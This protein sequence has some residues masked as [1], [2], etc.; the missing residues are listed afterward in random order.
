MIDGALRAAVRQQAGDRCEFCGMLQKHTAFAR[1]HIEHVIPRQHAGSDDPAN[2]ALACY[3]CNLHKGPNLTGI[4][5][6]TTQITP[7]FHP[8]RQAW[9]EHFAVRGARIVGLTSVGRVTVQVL[10]MNAVDRVE[11]RS[12]Q[13]TENES[14]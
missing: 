8:R 13:A 6:A 14:T 3:H 11:L 7:L 9:H 12:E 1:F 5:P 10:N 2:L 4:D